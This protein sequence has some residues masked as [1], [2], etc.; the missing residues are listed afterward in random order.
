MIRFGFI[1]TGRISDWVLKGAN[2][3][4]RISVRAICSRTEEAA[5]VFIARHPELSGARIYTSVQELAE[6]PDID[7]VY[8]GTPNQ[9]HHGYALTLLNAG[10]NVLCEKPFAVSAEEARQM[11]E[12]ARANGCLLME[13]MISTFNPNFRA[14]ADKI[15]SIGALRQY[16][17]NYCQYSSK[18]EGLKNGIT[19]SCF[20]SGTAGALRDIGIY[21]LYPLVS[22]FGRPER[23]SSCLTVFQTSEGP[24]DIHGS[25]VLDYGQMQASVTYSKVCDSL[26]PTEL[27]G[28]GG[29]LILD[30]I[31]IA[32]K[33]E[34]AP[35]NPPSSG[36]GPKPV[37]TV[38][39]EGLEH[40]E[41]YYEFKEFAD[42]IEAGKTESE[43]NSLDTSIITMEII[44]RSLQENGLR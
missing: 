23:T 31:R 4:P 33:T 41:Y 22:L 19:A 35:H 32:R 36:Q 29:N 27:S 43:I 42:L 5:K 11:A 26:V 28:E 1:G 24:T 13:A 7:A 14:F 12:A 3:D 9:T 38:I 17:S 6:D 20:Q 44:D 30:D 37:R 40:N 18:Y 16:S 10:K 39:S 8:I 21:A 2:E 15:Y 34:F 25:I